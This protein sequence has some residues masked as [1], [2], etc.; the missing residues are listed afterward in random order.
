MNEKNQEI[1]EFLDSIINNDI[2]VSRA[3]DFINEKY[4]VK[5]E[6]DHETST[7]YIWSPNILESLNVAAAGDYLRN[8]FKPEMLNI[9]YG[10]KDNN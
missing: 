10:M 7:L 5:S 9:V 6:Y 4:G 3:Q 8:E 2:Y 1:V